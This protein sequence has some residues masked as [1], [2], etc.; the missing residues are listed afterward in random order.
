[1]YLKKILTILYLFL[2]SQAVD[3]ILAPAI[4]VFIL[5][6]NKQLL[7]LPFN[8]ANWINVHNGMQSPD[9][10]IKFVPTPK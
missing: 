7:I 5:P 2:C 3:F 4:I 1:M 6:T 9:L 8:A 10:T